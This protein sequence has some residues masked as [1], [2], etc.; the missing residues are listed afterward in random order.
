MGVHEFFKR[1]NDKIIIGKQSDDGRTLK[2][3]SPMLLQFFNAL[4]PDVTLVR[5]NS[6]FTKIYET[7][8]VYYSLM[9]NIVPNIVNSI[10]YNAHKNFTLDFRKEERKSE[11]RVE[12]VN[13]LFVQ[14][15]W[16]H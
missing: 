14:Y 2:M 16:K 6:D 12:E 8:S 11:E 10:T 13:T 9:H 15:A 4:S 7:L 1:K 3:T 5:E